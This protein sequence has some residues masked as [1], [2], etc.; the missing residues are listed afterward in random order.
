MENTVGVSDFVMM[1][2][3][4]EKAFIDNLIERFN[5]DKIYTYIGANGNVVVS[6]NPYKAV[7][8]YKK[9]D[10]ECYVGRNTWQ[11]PPHIYA[12]ADNAYRDMLKNGLDQC[13]LVT[14]ESGAGKTEA[15]KQLMG[16]IVAVSGNS[17]HGEEIKRYLLE[18]NPLLEAFGNSCTLRNYNS[19]RFGKLQE[20]QFNYIGVPVGGKVT[21]YLLEKS[22]VVE[23]NV[24]ERSFHFFYQLLR[25]ASPELLQQLMLSGKPEDYH[26][27][28][29]SELY[30]VP[31]MDDA[32]EYKI[33]KKAM[34]VLGFDD[35]T[36]LCINRLIAAV[37]KLGNVA[38][39]EAENGDCSIDNIDLV[40]EIA[41]LLQ[42][43]QEK[44]AHALIYRS[45]TT[46]VTTTQ[47]PLKK[48][49]CL[50]ARDAL[51][52]ALYDHL[53]TWIVVKLNE[54]IRFDNSEPTLN[55][56][57]LDIYGFE[58]LQTN[59]LEQL[60]IN[61][62]NEKLQQVF[63]ERTLKKEQEEYNSEGVAW[64]EVKYFDNRIICELIESKGT[65]LINTLNDTCQMSQTSVK[66]LLENYDRGF[67]AHNHYESYLASKD[68]TIAADSFRL[69]HYAGD[70]TYSVN[71]FISRNLDILSNN[72]K[73]A[74]AASDSEFIRG[75]FPEDNSK[76]RPDTVTVKYRK[77]VNE[78][79]DILMGC[80]PHYVRC[81]K[82]NSEKKANTVDYE[83]IKH[84]V[85]YLGLLENVRVRRAGFVYRA[86][87]ERFVNRYKMTC[88]AT[89]PNP[90]MDTTPAAAAQLIL[91]NIGVDEDDF[92]VGKTKIFIRKPQTIFTLETAR[93]DKLPAIV[94]LIQAHLRG[95]RQRLWLRRY[96]AARRVQAIWRGY[97]CQRNW[98]KVKAAIK[99]GLCY[100]QYQASRFFRQLPIAFADV[101]ADP[102]LGRD[103]VWP[104]HD[105]GIS[106][107]VELLHAVHRTWRAH[108]MVNALSDT[109][110]RAVRRKILAFDLFSNKRPW[111]SRK[112][113]AESYGEVSA[114]ALGQLMATNGDARTVFAAPVQKISHKLKPQPRVLFLSNKQLY[115]LEGPML[116]SKKSPIPFSAIKTV[117][118]SPYH[119]QLV[120]LQCARP[121][122]DLLVDLSC[123]T[124]TELV[125]EFI[126]G[127]HLAMAAVNQSFVLKIATET[128][129]NNG[130][131][132]CKLT[133]VN[134]AGPKGNYGVTKGKKDCH[135]AFCP[136]SF[137]TP[138][139]SN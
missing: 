33:V 83:C 132:D 138:T 8:L 73:G 61:Y 130:G 4:T 122:L 115:R 48:E 111:D 58:V 66:L 31:G 1:N 105:Q 117:V 108:K 60:M 69:R 25:G 15:T 23:R 42:V 86:E 54:R 106:H 78:L 63:I 75:L 21:N 52:K 114:T 79:I 80:E 113:Y 24:G 91:Q 35:E 20:I 18:S 39:Q 41:E 10:I 77:A 101:S 74:M 40:N 5:S 116:K 84:Q 87:Y 137:S 7:S 133:F 110:K 81:I 94:T 70:V 107:G 46:G 104:A 43:D 127:L 85:L 50:P 12:L 49:E 36:E 55:M 19:S 56:G 95:Y 93:I 30:D 126:T 129:F 59:S 13:V 16:Y 34:K 90:Q 134:S 38:F 26:Y 82:P 28:S 88:T 121:E 67:A 22:R 125:S 131:K 112:K 65:S 124:E 27:L 32:Q 6:V 136:P 11:N 57:L 98:E 97:S 139:H 68:K 118:V 120:V 37:L 135:S 64:Q 96:K 123:D 103:V 128:T 47:I 76:K 92:R 45:I 109:E 44:L 71:Y 53:F 119:D 102:H 62:T 89:W 99:I 100:R 72:A 9:E 3:V 29:H 14:G 17:C 2:E 51:A